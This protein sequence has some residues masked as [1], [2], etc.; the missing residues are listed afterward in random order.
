MKRSPCSLISNINIIK[1]AILTKAIY[2]INAIPI[3]I[4]KQF[5]TDLKRIIFNFICV[6][7]TPEIAKTIQYNKETSEGITIYNFKLYYRAI[8]MLALA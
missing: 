8:V 4:P 1:M 5:F 7:E 2:R 6:N 3:K